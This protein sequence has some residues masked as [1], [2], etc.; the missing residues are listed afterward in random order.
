MEPDVFILYVRFVVVSFFLGDLKEMKKLLV[1]AWVMYL[2][3]SADIL[4]KAAAN[5]G[6]IF[7]FQ[8]VSAVNS[9]EAEKALKGISL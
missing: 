5:P 1:N 7:F 9:Q 6:W 4:Q 8:S 3:L 2:S